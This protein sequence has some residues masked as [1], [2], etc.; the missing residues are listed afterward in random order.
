MTDKLNEQAE[1][2]ELMIKMKEDEKMMLQM[3]LNDLT[4]E[5]N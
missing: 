4:E 3:A 5:T 1:G 2:Y